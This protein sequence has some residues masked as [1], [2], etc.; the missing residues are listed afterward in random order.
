[1]DQQTF[2]GGY[3]SYS[4]FTNEK[5]EVQSF[6]SLVRHLVA[7]QRNQLGLAKAIKEFLGRFFRS[8]PIP[9]KGR[10]PGTQAGTKGGWAA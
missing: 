1:M 4:F 9:Q 8:L 5:T 2:D 7:N 3:S 6:K 10:W